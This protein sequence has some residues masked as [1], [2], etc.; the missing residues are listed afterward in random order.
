MK[1]Q[2]TLAIV[3]V[4]ALS[5]AANAALRTFT[6]N[7]GGDAGN[8]DRVITPVGTTLN[9]GYVDGAFNNNTAGSLELTSVF[10]VNHS[11]S[12]F[13][14]TLDRIVNVP[15]TRYNFWF[16]ASDGT[17]LRIEFNTPVFLQP[18]GTEL[19]DGFDDVV[20]AA[21]YVAGVRNSAT[22]TNPAITIATVPEPSAFGFGA[23]ALAVTG[24]G[25]W[26]SRRFFAK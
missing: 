14:Y 11:S 3:V 9:F 12:P 19:P 7:F 25:R 8:P 26:V 1:I 5:S 22:A 21:I 4:L 6:I 2:H 18:S 20:D 17:E 15:N 24:L 13:T 10:S 16:T 23:L